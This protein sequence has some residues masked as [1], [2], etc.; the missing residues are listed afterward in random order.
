MNDYLIALFMYLF[1]YKLF[2]INIKSKQKLKYWSM[3]CCLA[4]HLKQRVLQVRQSP[5]LGFHSLITF[6]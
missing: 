2:N 5:L 4:T 6:C 1:N 3:S